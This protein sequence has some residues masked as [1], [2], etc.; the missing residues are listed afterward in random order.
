MDKEENDNVQ[1]GDK[2]MATVLSNKKATLQ[3][4]LDKISA[5]ADTLTGR[6]SKIG[7]NPNNPLH[8]E[9]FEDDKYEGK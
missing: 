6:D 4:M 1:K 7:L 5:K 2:D 9:W 8:K 3:E